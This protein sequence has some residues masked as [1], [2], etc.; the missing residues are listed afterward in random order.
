MNPRATAFEADA[1]RFPCRSHCQLVVYKAI[2]PLKNYK[3][4]NLVS[5]VFSNF[6]SITVKFQVLFN[7]Y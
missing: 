1:C 5:L 4:F 7:L 3:G 6:L 2:Q